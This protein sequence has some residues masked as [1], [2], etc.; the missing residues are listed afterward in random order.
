MAGLE[1]SGLFQQGTS[2]S[3]REEWGSRKDF[4]THNFSLTLFLGSNPKR[5][6]LNGQFHDDLWSWKLHLHNLYP[7]GCLS[8]R[9]GRAVSVLSRLLEPCLCLSTNYIIQYFVLIKISFQFSN[10]ICERRK[11]SQNI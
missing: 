4:D 10:A 9:E 6:K 3:N 11:S 5:K 7:G 1:A 2:Y 8:G